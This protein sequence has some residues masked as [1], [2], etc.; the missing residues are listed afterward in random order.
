MEQGKAKVDAAST[1][2]AK[3]T[4]EKDSAIASAKAKG[5]SDMDKVK[6][7]TVKELDTAKQ[8]RTGVLIVCSIPIGG[9]QQ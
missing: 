9:V 4:E 5:E 6:T 2:A 7:D 3:A 1:K 8:V